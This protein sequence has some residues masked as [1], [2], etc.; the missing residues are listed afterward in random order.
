MIQT[1]LLDIELTH[2]LEKNRQVNSEL[3]PRA[4]EKFHEKYAWTILFAIGLL[5]LVTAVPHSLG[6]NTD[7]ET[8]ERII[9][10]TLNEFKDSNPRFFDLYM[11]Y[12]SFGGLSDLGVA[13][14]IMAISLTAYRKGEK[15]AWYILWF[16]PAYFIGCAAI[17]LSTV[18]TSVESSLSLLLPIS[19]FV[20]LSLLGLFLPYRKFFPSKANLKA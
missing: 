9:G 19:M 8:V 11:F 16:V 2:E 1:G 20:I 3:H 14:F 17:T 6:I 12:F 5:V 15:F 7:P 4:N 10:M 18:T 13:F